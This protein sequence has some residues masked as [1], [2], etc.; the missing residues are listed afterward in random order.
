M[1]PIKLIS[2]L[3]ACG[4]YCERSPVCCQIVTIAAT[5][6]RQIFIIIIIIIIIITEVVLEAHKL[7][8]T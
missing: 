3:V 2:A 7:I 1:V 4:C 8:D 5:I 6:T